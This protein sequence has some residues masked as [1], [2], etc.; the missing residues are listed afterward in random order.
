MMWNQ[1]SHFEAKNI[2]S[3][4]YTV[5]VAANL[6]APGLTQDQ[7]QAVQVLLDNAGDGH[8]TV[9]GATLQQA[10]HFL[11]CIKEQLSS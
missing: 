11:D 1:P 8:K 9:I 3:L 2:Q 4:R 6:D 7:R 5:V 10:Q